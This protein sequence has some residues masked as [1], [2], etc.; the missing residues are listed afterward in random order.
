MNERGYVDVNFAKS[1]LITRSSRAVWRD[2]GQLKLIS[3]KKKE[4]SQLLYFL[5]MVLMN[6]RDKRFTKF[7]GNLCCLGNML[8][9]LKRLGNLPFSS[10]H[11]KTRCFRPSADRNFGKKLFIP[12]KWLTSEIE[13]HGLSENLVFR[14]C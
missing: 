1:L 7:L 3:D 14:S 5:Q 4:D 9:F 6:S 12:S 13:V 8:Q 11:T 2:L 10:S